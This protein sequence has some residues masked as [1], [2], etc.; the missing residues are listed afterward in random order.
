MPQ[1]QK[2][3]RLACEWVGHCPRCGLVIFSYD[4]MPRTCQNRIELGAHTRRCRC[5]LKS[6]S[7]CPPSGE[8]TALPLAA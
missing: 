8:P 1:K 6:V 5:T 2:Q 3:S 7:L 4:R